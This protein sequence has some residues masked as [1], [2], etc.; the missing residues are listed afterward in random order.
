MT[1]PSQYIEGIYASQGFKVSCQSVELDLSSSTTQGKDFEGAFRLVGC[2]NPK[3]LT[4]VQG[5]QFLN[6]YMQH[7]EVCSV[8]GSKKRI[9]TGTVDFYF[10]S[11]G[12][13]VAA[14]LLQSFATQFSKGA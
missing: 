11:A 9:P 6:F 1:T 13:E 14:G 2:T 8:D 10:T 4:S 5:L 7:T 3:A 12:S